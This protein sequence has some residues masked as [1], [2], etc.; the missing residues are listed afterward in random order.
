VL[1]LT[2]VLFSVDDCWRVFEKKNKRE[3]ERKWLLDPNLKVSRLIS[4]LFWAREVWIL[5]SLARGLPGW[6]RRLPLA[7]PGTG[8]RY[9][10]DNLRA[11]EL[12]VLDV[13]SLE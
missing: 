6:E 10:F 7:K 5:E 13:D 1:I 11:K 3:E 4:S 2:R 8:L 12:V 9:V